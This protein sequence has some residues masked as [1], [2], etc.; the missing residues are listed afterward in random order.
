MHSAV[1]RLFHP[2]KGELGNCIGDHCVVDYNCSS[3]QLMTDA[4]SAVQILAPH[5]S[6]QSIFTVIGP[7]NRLGFVF[8]LHDGHAGP[9]S[10]PAHDLH[11]MRHVRQDSRL[12]KHTLALAS[13]RN[14]F[15]AF[16][17]CILDVVLDDLQLTRKGD[18][19]TI[20][21]T[22][23]I[24]SVPDLEL[25]HLSFHCLYKPIIHRFHHVE[26]LHGHAHLPGVVV[27]RPNAPLCRGVNIRV[28]EHNHR[29]LPS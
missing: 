26:P 8:D 29:I 14:H 7:T 21:G 1:A 17:E 18:R 2:A 3:F 20:V 24:G 5:R 6:R 4:F 15:S 10:L 22:I 25:A 12:D 9:K 28:F 11:L 19:P 13:A 23:D 27:G 16:G